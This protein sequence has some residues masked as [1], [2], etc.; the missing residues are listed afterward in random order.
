[1][2]I[3]YG[4]LNEKEQKNMVF[5]SGDNG[6]KIWISTEHWMRPNQII[7]EGS[8]MPDAI[9]NLLQKWRKEVHFITENYENRQRVEKA[10]MEFI[11]EDKYFELIPGSIAATHE[12]CHSIADKIKKDLKHLGCP[13][14]KY[15]WEMDCF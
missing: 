10:S 6:Q 7:S 5:L 9:L 15:N 4:E 3:F 12:V 1:M 8:E 13:Y 11:Y 14:T 2:S